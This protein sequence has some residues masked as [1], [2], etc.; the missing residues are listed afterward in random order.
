M[1]PD[2]VPASKEL[3][4]LDES[5]KLQELLKAMKVYFRC[6]QTTDA[7]MIPCRGKIFYISVTK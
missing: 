1:G 5:V 3:V 2:V 6:S 4:H 7:F